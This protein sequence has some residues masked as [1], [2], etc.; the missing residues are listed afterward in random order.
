MNTKDTATSLSTLLANAL[1]AQAHVPV[2]VGTDFMPLV[3]VDARMSPEV[4][5]LQ[6]R[7][8]T[9]GTCL[10]QL[11]AGELDQVYGQVDVRWIYA[12]GRANAFF[13]HVV[14]DAPLLS[15]PVAV[16]ALRAEFAVRF[17]LNDATVRLLRVIAECRRVLL[18]F[19]AEPEWVQHLPPTSGNEQARD[20]GE[21]GLTLVRSSLFLLFRPDL[22][23]RMAGQ[24]DVWERTFEQGSR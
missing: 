18:H 14:V 22:I 15:S 7:L 11:S 2:V 10:G 5:L 3:W 16:P 4:I 13:L 23:A 17:S 24:L 20:M 6:A 19:D 21:R 8:S 12:Y 9:L 1:P